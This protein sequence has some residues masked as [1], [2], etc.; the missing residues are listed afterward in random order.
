MKFTH[1]E[2]CSCGGRY[3]FSAYGDAEFQ[4]ATCP[5][6]AKPGYLSDPLSV[7]V[8]AERLL[9]RS[10]AELDAGDY[11]FSILA[12]V[13]AVESFL[14]RLFLKVK[15]MDNYVSTFNLPTP[16]E[17]T[18]WEKE[19]PRKGGFPNPADFVSQKLAGQTFDKFIAGNK[20]AAA[21][22]SNV[23]NNPQD[24][25]TQYVQKELF[26]RRNRIAHWGYVNSTQKDAEI[27]HQ[28]A[29]FVVTILREMD[30]LKYGNL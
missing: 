19:Y 5:S 17:E 28:I 8:T 15:G 23:P 11:S 13:M 26:N 2:A 29:V 16:M 3:V 12:A 9:Y 30:R 20:T 10:K 25:P 24:S 18:Q 7:S 4:P 1:E 21:T 27:C 14:T 22:F 6:C